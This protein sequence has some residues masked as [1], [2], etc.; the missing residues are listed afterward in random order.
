[1]HLLD[2]VWA[3]LKSYNISST[4][5]F[6]MSG[7]EKELDPILEDLNRSVEAEE[8]KKLREAFIAR[9]ERFK[10]LVSDVIN[11]TM[12]EYARYLNERGQT[13]RIIIHWRFFD[14]T[15]E[16]HGNDLLTH[17]Y[18]GILEFSQA[19]DRIKVVEQIRGDSIDEIYNEDQITTEL[20]KNR[21]VIFIK[22]FY[23]I[24]V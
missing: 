24:Y 19:N 14:I 16:I 18:I 5:L 4:Y 9:H 1:M 12:I 6:S 10:T 8:A 2:P 15:F 22:N 11:P 7:I 13:A 23:K 20:V 21:V 3:Q 17:G